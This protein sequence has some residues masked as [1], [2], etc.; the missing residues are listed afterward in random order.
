MKK[1][2]D[3]SNPWDNLLKEGIYD[4]QKPE[5]NLLKILKESKK[6]KGNAL[7]L[8]CGMGR[9]LYSLKEQGYHPIG[10]DISSSAIH[11]IKTMDAEMP[12]IVGDMKF[13][14]FENESLDLILAWRSVYLQ[15]SKEMLQSVEEIKRTLKPRGKLIAALRS[16]QN[17]L[18]F[19]GK[20]KGEEIEKNTFVIDDERH[21][22]GVIFHFCD[23]HEVRKVFSW[24]KISYLQEEIL[25][26][27]KY[28]RGDGPST[29]YYWIL[30][31]EKP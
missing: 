19:V 8:G 1:V 26:D 24:L 28:T 5:T 9:H 7:D 27:T 3:I 13:L 17:T 21:L 16:T 30:V 2:K 18:Y 14:P 15:T 20:E 23:E 12:V 31:G 25:E 29:N 6:G 22:K 4:L 10:L 11:Y